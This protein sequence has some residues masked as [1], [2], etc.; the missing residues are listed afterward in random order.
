[1]TLIEKDKKAY[2]NALRTAPYFAGD[3]IS[4]FYGKTK[5]G[6]R[7]LDH[8]PGVSD[9]LPHHAVQRTLSGI[10]FVWS[11]CL[12]F[13]PASSCS[14]TE[15]KFQ[16]LTDSLNYKSRDIINADFTHAR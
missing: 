2:T 5:S 8:C 7:F 15:D 6:S 16:H 1:M 9:I 12:H 14:C 10:S 3:F 4:L 13:L 11:I